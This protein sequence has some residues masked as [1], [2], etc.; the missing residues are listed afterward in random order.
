MPRTG[1]EPAHPCEWQILSLLRLPIPPPGP[2]VQIIDNLKC[3]R[4]GNPDYEPGHNI[5]SMIVSLQKAV[6]IFLSEI[7]CRQPI[8]IRG[9]KVYRLAGH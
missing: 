9:R 3:T 1:I 5:T 2:F 6:N 4:P 8:E 7:I